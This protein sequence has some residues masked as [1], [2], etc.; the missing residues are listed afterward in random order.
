M[1]PGSLPTSDGASAESTI[2]WI[3]FKLWRVK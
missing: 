1:I 2:L 3:V